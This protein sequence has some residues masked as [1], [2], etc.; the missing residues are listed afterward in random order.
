MKESPFYNFY[1]FT[2]SG[3]DRARL[4]QE[5]FCDG[6]MVDVYIWPD[7][8]KRE[9][10]DQQAIARNRLAIREGN[11]VSL[12]VMMYGEIREAA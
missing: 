5:V 8:M 2:P 9:A 4:V 7:W 1:T 10:C 3:G 6:K 12:Y 11:H